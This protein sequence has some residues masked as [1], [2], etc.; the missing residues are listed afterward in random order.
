MFCIV[1][2]STMWM[3]L[4]KTIMVSAHLFRVVLA[5]LWGSVSAYLRS[6]QAVQRA[7]RYC[8]I[9]W[10]PSSSFDGREELVSC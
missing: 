4:A 7:V 10:G 8:V 5:V 6:I 2:A 3:L 9:T 1:A